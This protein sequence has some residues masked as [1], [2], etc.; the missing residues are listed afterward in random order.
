M[1]IRRVGP[2]S[3]AKIGGTLYGVMGIFMG[4]VFW[5]IAT[6]G[7]MAAGASSS[8][9]FPFPFPF[10]MVFGAAA[11]FILPIFYGCMGF[12]T[13]LIGA[14]LYNAVAGFVGGIELETE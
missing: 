2:L 6:A 7:G 1:M 12:V 5:V 3:C 10:S 8:N 14:V 4:L 11:I 13:T 9:Q